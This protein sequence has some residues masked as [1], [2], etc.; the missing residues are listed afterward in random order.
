MT[1]IASIDQVLTLV[2]RISNG[3]SM[4][5]AVKAAAG[6]LQESVKEQKVE[7]VMSKAAA[8]NTIE[9]ADTKGYSAA[10]KTAH[11]KCLQEL[12]KI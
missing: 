3:G 7:V 6:S 11:A 4:R 12:D 1:D 10:G 9:T 5:V 2:E 8:I